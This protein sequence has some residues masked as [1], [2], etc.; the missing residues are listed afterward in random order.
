MYAQPV[1]YLFLQNCTENGEQ[2]RK[3]IALKGLDTVYTLLT[4]RSATFFIFILNPLIL[5][6]FVF[7]MFYHFKSITILSL[8]E[9]LLYI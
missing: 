5:L 2:K 6:L 7:F 3:L 8:Q 9:D 1:N 4:D